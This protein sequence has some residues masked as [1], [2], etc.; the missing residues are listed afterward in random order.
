M[1]LHYNYSHS[2]KN[3]TTSIIETER[4]S[5]LGLCES[6]FIFYLQVEEIPGAHAVAHQENQNISSVY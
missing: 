5:G 6:L 4:V 3:R 1:L 2:K